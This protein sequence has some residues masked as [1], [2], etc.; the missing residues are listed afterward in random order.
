MNGLN[1]INFKK[2][3]LVSKIKNNDGVYDKYIKVIEAMSD[4]N[5][6]DY[7]AAEIKKFKNKKFTSNPRLNN[8]N[9]IEKVS[10]AMPVVNLYL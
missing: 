2:Q 7:E 3:M 4:Q 5:E 10:N 9:N 6:P 1:D 8:K